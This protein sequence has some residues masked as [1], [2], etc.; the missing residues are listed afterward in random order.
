MLWQ[1]P[2]CTAS[3]PPPP[4]KCQVEA[5]APPLDQPV[6]IATDTILSLHPIIHVQLKSW[7][8]G[9]F[10]MSITH[11]WINPVIWA[12][13]YQQI[14]GS[15]TR[16]AVY[17]DP[18]LFMKLSIFAFLKSE[19]YFQCYLIFPLCSAKTHGLTLFQAIHHQVDQ[20]PKNDP[21]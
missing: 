17:A 21:H 3:A 12:V 4:L 14:I 13:A 1:F 18:V 7:N 5:P 11:Y 9:Q 16:I 8:Y 20:D 15:L 6:M 2:S 10:S 19:W